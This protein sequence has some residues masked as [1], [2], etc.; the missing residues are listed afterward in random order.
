[1]RC[2]SI[3]LLIIKF[4]VAVVLSYAH[5]SSAQNYKLLQNERKVIMPVVDIEILR[6]GLYGGYHKRVD[7]TSYD[8]LVYQIKHG[9]EMSFITV[10]YFPKN[11]RWGFGM[12]VQELVDDEF[13]SYSPKA[14]YASMISIHTVYVLH[15][16]ILS[17]S[18]VRLRFSAYIG[19]FTSGA[20]ELNHKI[21]KPL[22]LGFTVRIGAIKNWK[23]GAWS[24]CAGYGIQI[25]AG[26][27][28]GLGW[29]FTRTN[30]EGI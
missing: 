10:T 11:S 22:T 8:T 17:L 14:F 30:S 16:S 20:V 29:W 4:I 24:S 15:C 18:T 13:V 2:S 26:I 27:T 25:G 6:F 12:N 7:Y 1:M 23:D 28:I 3:R 5:L 19:K 9:A 21:I